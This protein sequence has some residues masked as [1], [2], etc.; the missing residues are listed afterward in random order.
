MRVSTKGR[1]GLRVLLDMAIHQNEGPVTLHGISQRQAISEK[2]LWQIINPLKAAGLVTSTR[3]KKGGYGLGKAPGE[4]TLLD[5]VTILEGPVS[6]VDCEAES[7]PCERRGS[8]VTKEVWEQ[9]GHNLRES[10]RSITLKQMVARQKE[11]E[12]RRELSYVI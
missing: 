11:M 3:G 12:S 5:I 1:Y 2:Y 4:I 9:V 8:C 10:L 6:V 7:G